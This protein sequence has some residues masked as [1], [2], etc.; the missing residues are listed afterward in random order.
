MR[1]AD[2]CEHSQWS[3][4]P[5]V[6]RFAAAPRRNRSEAWSSPPGRAGVGIVVLVS[7]RCFVVSLFGRGGSVGRVTYDSLS[8]EPGYRASQLDMP[9]WSPIPGRPKAPWYARAVLSRA[10]IPLP[11]ASSTLLPSPP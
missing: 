11:T 8:A 1:Y 5:V 10:A 3:S 7:K 9:L 4:G 2:R 6:V